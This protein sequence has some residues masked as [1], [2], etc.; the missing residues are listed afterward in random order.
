MDGSFGHVGA[1]FDV[2]V[3]ICIRHEHLD[4]SLTKVN[5]RCEIQIPSKRLGIFTLIEAE[6]KGK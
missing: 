6:K 3:L 2:D 5:D 1:K 4:I